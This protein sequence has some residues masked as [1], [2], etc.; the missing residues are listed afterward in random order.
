MENELADDCIG[1]AS[2]TEETET[3]INWFDE[4][5]TTIPRS[6]RSNFGYFHIIFSKP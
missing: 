6:Q 5:T 3:F 4:L 1:L 2:A